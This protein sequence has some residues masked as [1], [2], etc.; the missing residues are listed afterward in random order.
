MDFDE[1]SAPLKCYRILASLPT[2]GAVNADSSIDQLLTEVRGV[3]K[4]LY[5]PPDYPDQSEQS[6][7]EITRARNSIANHKIYSAVFRWVP[8][9]YYGF[10]LEK[11][12]EILGSHST[13]QLCKS[14]LMENKAC[15]LSEE[16]EMYSQFYLLVLQYEASINTKKLQSEVRA[17]RPVKSRLDPSKYDFRVASEDDNARLTGYSH[18]AVSPFGMLHNVPVIL[19]KAIVEQSDMSPYVWMGGGHVHCKLGLAVSDFI[20]ALQPHILDFTDPRSVSAE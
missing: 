2:V 16:N 9:N 13:F 7:E 3:E 1:S 10:T 6:H 18:N 12:A 19:S 5:Y 4:S 11:R 20:R 17:L 8:D 14:M 15:I